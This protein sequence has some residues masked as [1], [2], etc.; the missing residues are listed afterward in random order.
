[1]VARA[2]TRSAFAVRERKRLSVKKSVNGRSMSKLLREIEEEIQRETLE[3]FHIFYDQY[4][5]YTGKGRDY[6]I[7]YILD[8]YM[9]ELGLTTH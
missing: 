2:A 7:D 4:L 8:E 3:G 6:W 9:Q 1:M 5:Q